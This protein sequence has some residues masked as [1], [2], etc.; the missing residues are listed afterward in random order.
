MTR[1]EY[2]AKIAALEPLAEE[3][4][5]SVTYIMK[6]TFEKLIRDTLEKSDIPLSASEIWQKAEVLGL[7]DSVRSS[8]KTPWKTIEAKIYVDLK[9]QRELNI[10]S[11][12]TQVSTHPAKFGLKSKTY[13]TVYR[14]HRAK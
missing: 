13:K 1:E 5:K 4:R 11:E 2:D 14:T 12:L 9:K 7:A 10:E 6:Y 8:G 3:Q